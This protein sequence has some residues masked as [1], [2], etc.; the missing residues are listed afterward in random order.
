MLRPSKN[1]SWGVRSI[2]ALGR[3]GGDHGSVFRYAILERHA[4]KDR[5]I[6]RLLALRAGLARVVEYPSN[7]RQRART[8]SDE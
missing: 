1:N 6:D 2:F 5:T 3:G 4:V 7:K 8:N